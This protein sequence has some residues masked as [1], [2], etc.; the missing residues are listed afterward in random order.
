[1]GCEMCAHLLTGSR[2]RI[3]R[4]RADLA[5]FFESPGSS[6][7]E[8]AD[9]LRPAEQQRLRTASLCASIT[10][11]RFLVRRLFTPPRLPCAFP[12]ERGYHSEAKCGKDSVNMEILCRPPACPT[13]VRI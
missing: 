12:F 9:H 11:P 7:Q 8:Q 4:E 10:G 3:R 1:M 5:C 2:C 13:S 6:Q